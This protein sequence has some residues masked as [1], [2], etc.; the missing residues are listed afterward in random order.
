MTADILF[1]S[2]STGTSSEVQ[3]L[4]SPL[5]IPFCDTSYKIFAKVDML[6]STVDK[7]TD[8]SVSISVVKSAMLPELIAVDSTI[9]STVI[10]TFIIL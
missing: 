6:V 10:K 3:F 5:I 2:V 1:E 4:N 8:V 7:G 9:S